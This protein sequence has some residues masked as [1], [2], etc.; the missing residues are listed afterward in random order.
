MV[1]TFP[2]NVQAGSPQ[3]TLASEISPTSSTTSISVTNS[4]SIVPISNAFYTIQNE[5]GSKWCTF[6][7]GQWTTDSTN[8]YTGTCT[9]SSS[10][11]SDVFPE[12]SICWC[13]WC[14]EYYDSLVSKIGG[15]AVKSIEYDLA[16]TTFTITDTNDQVTEINTSPSVQ[17]NELPPY[18]F[19]GVF[20]DQ[21]G[22]PLMRFGYHTGSTISNIGDMDIVTPV[23]SQTHEIYFDVSGADLYVRKESPA[24]MYEPFLTYWP[25]QEGKDSIV[26]RWR[27]NDIIRFH[28]PED[29]FGVNY[30][31][32]ISCSPAAYGWACV[33]IYTDTHTYQESHYPGN[34]EFPKYSLNSTSNIVYIY[35]DARAESELTSSAYEIYEVTI[36]IARRESSGAH[37]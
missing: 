19:S 37:E 11:T 29:N 22:A 26:V 1:G 21:S 4:D 15:V 2:L 28:I 30:S 9:Y 17:G 34:F 33:D 31:V 36:S 23:L 7:I 14:K 24:G 16:T 18:N 6:Y 12:G 32:N 10:N 8:N 35:C 27:E 13:I 25:I 20:Y 3:Y 5:E